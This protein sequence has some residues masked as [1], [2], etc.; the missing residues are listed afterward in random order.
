[1]F[2]LIRD[3]EQFKGVLDRITTIVHLYTKAMQLRR[4]AQSKKCFW[5][6]RVD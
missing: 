5:K 4:K 3:G 1:M 2:W 6:T